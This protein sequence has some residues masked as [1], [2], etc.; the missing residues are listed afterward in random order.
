M[1]NRLA[2]QN[3]NTSEY[4]SST[5]GTAHSDWL[6]WSG[7]TI[8]VLS[9]V[10]STSMAREKRETSPLWLAEGFSPDFLSLLLHIL[11]VQTFEQKPTDSL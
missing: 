5:V 3:N 1:D 8:V 4:K 6:M 2:L 7:R 9:I 11:V 10:L